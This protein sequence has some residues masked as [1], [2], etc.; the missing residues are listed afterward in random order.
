MTR[1]LL[2][3]ALLLA[4]LSIAGATFLNGLAGLGA[5]ALASAGVWLIGLL[6]GW[7]GMAAPMLFLLSGAAAAAFLLAAPSTVETAL[8]LGGGLAAFLAWDL[9]DFDARLALAEASDRP[10]LE[11]AHFSRLGLVVGS[12]VLLI[13]LALTLAVKLN[14]EWTALLVLI[15]AGGLG[16]LVSQIRSGR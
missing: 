1:P 8:L 2:L 10:R 6:R 7:K 11:R 14:F 12:S 15:G 3:L 5:V 13:L 16:Y 9:T 4:S